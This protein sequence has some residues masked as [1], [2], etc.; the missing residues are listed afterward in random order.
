MSFRLR[1]EAEADIEAITLYIAEHAP[2]AAQAW[3]DDTSSATA[4][5]SAPCPAWASP[6]RR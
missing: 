2:R 4:A 1:P 6:G 3:Y 5:S